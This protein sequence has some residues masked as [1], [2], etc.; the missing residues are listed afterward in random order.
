MELKCIRT[1]LLCAF[2]Q[3]DFIVTLP[4]QKKKQWPPNNS[5]V[6]LNEVHN[7]WFSLKFNTSQ[8]RLTTR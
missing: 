5:V 2:I 7:K 6:L 8:R 4:L 1:S 3:G